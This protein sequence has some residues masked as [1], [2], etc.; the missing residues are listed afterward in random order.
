M[1]VRFGRSLQE[2]TKHSQMLPKTKGE[3][4]GRNLRYANQ[5]DPPR[6]RKARY[7]HST[8]PQVIERLNK[9]DFSWEYMCLLL[10]IFW[11]YIFVMNFK[12]FLYI[13]GQ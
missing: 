9:V 10:L 1:L 12:C 4:H 11:C 5:I 3:R 8:I 6:C 2:A 13:V 7:Q